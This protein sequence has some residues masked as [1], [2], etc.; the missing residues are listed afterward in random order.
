M[1]GG[2]KATEECNREDF[3]YFFLSLTARIGIDLSN[4]TIGEMV[5]LSREAQFEKQ[6]DRACAA[7]SSEMMPKI[8]PS[9]EELKARKAAMEAKIKQQFAGL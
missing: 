4:Y 7:Q 3:H 1:E 8:P 6:I 2:G 5:T 9:P